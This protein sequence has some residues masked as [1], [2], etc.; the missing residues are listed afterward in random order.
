M[1]ETV[2]TR[3]A[4]ARHTKGLSLRQLRDL[5]GIAVNTI[6]RLE[7]DEGS[8]FARSIYRVAESLDL[9]VDELID[10]LELEEIA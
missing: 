3:I 5:S 9:D 1:R 8:P 7:N 4:K 10:L 6:R 2:G